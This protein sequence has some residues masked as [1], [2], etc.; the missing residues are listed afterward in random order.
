LLV[1]VLPMYFALWWL[2]TCPF[3]VLV[4]CVMSLYSILFFVRSSRSF[5][6]SQ[7]SLTHSSIPSIMQFYWALLALFLRSEGK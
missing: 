4:E 6:C 7:F 5:A 3:L 1:R 2:Q